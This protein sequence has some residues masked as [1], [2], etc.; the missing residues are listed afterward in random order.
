M[1]SQ[2][3]GE[4]ASR[5]A[6]AVAALF[7]WTACDAPFLAVKPGPGD[8]RG[9][10]LVNET[11]KAVL[12]A[13]CPVVAQLRVQNALSRR[14]KMVSPVRPWID[15]KPDLKWKAYRKVPE[16]LEAGA[17]WDGVWLLTESLEP[18]RYVVH[19]GKGAGVTSE[20]ATV[21]ITR[22]K[23]SAPVRAQ[24][25]CI[26]AK[27]TGE[28][29]QVLEALAR[30]IEAGL[31]P[32]STYLQLAELMESLGDRAAAR[33]QYEQF[34]ERVYGNDELP[35]WLQSKLNRLEHE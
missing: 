11:P 12:G 5:V 3:V 26:A 6:A 14:V 35:G 32:P 1:R 18:G 33:R 8:L 23:L 25:R 2:R 27:L 29:D 16:T 21:E 17:T 19:S 34:A 20:A 15:G 13:D 4:M 24:Q 9:Q 10:W 7:V 22:E 30:E 31:A 28:V